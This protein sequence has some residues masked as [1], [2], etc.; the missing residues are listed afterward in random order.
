MRMYAIDVVE[1][2]QAQDFSTRLMPTLTYLG[3]RNQSDPA[4]IQHQN[5]VGKLGEFAVRR[6]LQ[7]Q[8][9]P[10]SP[11]NLEVTT[12]KTWDADLLIAGRVRVHVKSQDVPSAK[13]FGLS[14]SFGIG[15]KNGNQGGHRD[16]EIFDSYRD[17]DQVVFCLVNEEDGWVGICAELPVH[18]LHDLNL[19][20]DP[21][22]KALIGIKK[23]VCFKDIPIEYRVY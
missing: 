1:L 4:V 7:S 11:V 23:V 8:G 20:H 12:H 14:W 19:F 5:V 15:D 6:M 21:K 9:H 10:V 16:K 22:K 17:V 3:S 13:G 2:E 18:K